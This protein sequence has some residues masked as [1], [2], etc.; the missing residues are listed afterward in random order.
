MLNGIAF[1]H[2]IAGRNERALIFVQRCI[3]D[4]P[5]FLAGHRMKIAALSTRLTD[6]VS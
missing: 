6:A 4:L 5:H 2:L 3:D 1:S